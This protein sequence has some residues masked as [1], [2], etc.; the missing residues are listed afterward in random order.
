MRW[1]EHLTKMDHSKGTSHAMIQKAMKLEIADL[2]RKL[3]EQERVVK[4]N[5]DAAARWRMAATKY[6]KLAAQR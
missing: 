2:K 1:Q 6:Q 4:Y 5:K 3:R